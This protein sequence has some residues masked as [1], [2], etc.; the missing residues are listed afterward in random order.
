MV[1]TNSEA[2][3]KK[4]EIR[5]WPVV[6]AYGTAAGKYPLM[7]TL[8]FGASAVVEAMNVISPLYM[9]RFINTVAMAQPSP[10]TMH[11]LL[12]IL[13][14]YGGVTLIGWA[15][16]RVQMAAL[17]QVESKTEANLSNDAFSNLLAHSHDFFISNFA[18]SLTRK[19]SRYS[20]SFEQL[21]DTLVFTFFSTFAFALGTVVVLS[22]RNIY[23]G[24]GI[25]LWTVIFVALQLGLANWRQPLRVARAE[26]D[27]KLTG[28]LS[29]AVSNQS[30]VSQFARA[31]HERGIFAAA[32]ANWRAA[33]M[34]S[35][36]MDNAIF[37]IQGLFAIAVEV[38]LLAV[39]VALWQRGIITVG[40][41]VL[42]QVYVIGLVNNLWGIGNSMRRVYEALADAYEMIVILETPLEV[43]DATDAQELAVPHGAIVARSVDFGFKESKLILEDFNLSI[44]A[45]E[46]VALVG[47]S[48]AGKSTVTK[49]L[50]RLYD[51]TGGSIEIDG[52]DISKVTQ[53]SLRRAIAF[54]PQ[55][56]ILFHRSLMDNIRYGRLDA[57]D[58]EVIE[59]AKKAHCHDFITALPEGYETHVGER[60]VKLSGGE[61]QRVAIARAI[62]KNA[63]ILILDEAT[64]ALDSESEH[65]IQDAL[66]TLMAGKTVIVIAHRLSTIMTMDR[67][68][69]IEGGRIAA[70]GT[71]T[72]L[73][74]Q[75]GG[76]YHKLWSIQAGSFLTD[77]DNELGIN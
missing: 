63:P 45:G 77:A 73:L 47:P 54:V 16:R 20:R 15:G 42:I 48:G 69:V 36:R 74:N 62:L 51:V 8:T 25:L 22:I 58:D 50:L 13:L 2:K 31:E 32:V 46:K 40:D 41:F 19:V 43:M 29:D 34:R 33:T 70:Q 76:L 68:V 18:G 66:K 17:I 5:T 60:G 53:E 64:S 27:T 4:R 71:H 30:T 3:P 23:L 65:L 10:A 75:E 55:E 35:W 57:T 67:I 38:G 59:A 14:S 6:R 52:Q 12:V 1:E 9:R 37:A 49:L 39:G 11:T 56:P 44:S 61:R 26:A 21:M 7:V 28:A 72:E 24:M